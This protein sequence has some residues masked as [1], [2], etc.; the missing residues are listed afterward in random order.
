[1]GEQ[2]DD[3]QLKEILQNVRTIAVVG[4]SSNTS[5]AS[6]GVAKYLQGRGYTI[7]P[8]N[9]K[10]D[11]VL[12]AKSYPDL[13]ALPEPPDVVN[14]FR[15]PEAVPEI[16]DQAVE[17]GAKVLWLQ[18]GISHDEAAGRARDAGLTVIQDA[19]MLQEHKR[20]L[21]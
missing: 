7:I 9:P 11:E 19:C 16:A 4:L 18:L 17:I 21:G 3:G 13:R 2:P 20:L 6:H 15:R 10:E 8:V 1:M 5:K 12:G 14:V